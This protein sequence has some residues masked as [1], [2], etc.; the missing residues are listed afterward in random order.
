MPRRTVKE[1]E[2]GRG[3]AKAD[4]DEVSDNLE[5][6]TEDFARAKPFPE[7]FPE[8]AASVPRKRGAQRSPTKTLISLRIDHDVLGAFEATGR[9]AGENERGA[10]QGGQGHCGLKIQPVHD[11]ADAPCAASG[12]AHN[13][14][15][16]G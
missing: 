12:R 8:L 5:W 14:A 9:L 6:T 15:P 1:F 10:V 11:S 16:I 2:P 4:W 3:Y 7:V 13:R